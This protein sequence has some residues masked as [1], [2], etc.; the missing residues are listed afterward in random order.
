MEFMGHGGV[1]AAPVLPADRLYPVGQLFHRH[2]PRRIVIEQVQ[3]PG[4]GIVE[5]RRQAVTNGVAN[6]GQF[7]PLTHGTAP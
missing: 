3:F 4:H 6:D 5:Q 2:L 7:V 1:K